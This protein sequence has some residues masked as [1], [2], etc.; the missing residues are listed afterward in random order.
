MEDGF[1]RRSTAE[2]RVPEPSRDRRGLRR[3]SAY[4]FGFGGVTPGIFWLGAEAFALG[5]AGFLV[6]PLLSFMA[7]SSSVPMNA[8]S[9]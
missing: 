1:R 5:A 9:R 6:L 4:F 7:F 2:G 3:G 8:S